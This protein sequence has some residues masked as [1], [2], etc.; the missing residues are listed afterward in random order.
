VNQHASVITMIVSVA[1]NVITSFDDETGLAKLACN[2]LG[3][4]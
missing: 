3:K 4:H 2:P 1:S